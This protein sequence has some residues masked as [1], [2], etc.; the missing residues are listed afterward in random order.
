[1]QLS[2]MSEG[3]AGVFGELG[4]TADCLLRF[5]NIKHA[6]RTKMQFTMSECVCVCVYMHVRS[7]PNTLN[8]LSSEFGVRMKTYGERGHG[9][10]GGVV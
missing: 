4:G 10:L 1:M 5:R 3:N 6:L 7:L 2:E 8:V 9:G